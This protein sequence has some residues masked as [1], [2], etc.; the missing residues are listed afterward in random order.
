MKCWGK[1]MKRVAYGIIMLLSVMLFSGCGNSNYAKAEDIKILLL[2]GQ[3][4]EIF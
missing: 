2:I 4:K 1:F 3:Q